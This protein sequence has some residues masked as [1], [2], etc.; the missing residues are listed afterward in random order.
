MLELTIPVDNGLW[1]TS[2]HRLNRWDK[3]RRVRSLRE[4]A[5]WTA[6]GVSAERKL[7]RP[8]FHRC[9]VDVG[10]Q[11]PI[12]SRADPSNTAPCVK[13]ML[14]GLTDAG[15]WLDDDSEHVVSVS[16]RRT[17]GKC[18]RGQH[19]FTLTITEL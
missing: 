12:A 10:I 9:K 5:A 14:D 18:R 16:Y 1:F 15:W 19:V 13:P 4:L 17:P 11:Y 6:V 8:V 7:H 2:N 3:A